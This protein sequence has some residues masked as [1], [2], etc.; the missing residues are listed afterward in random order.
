MDKVLRPECLDTDPNS[1][2]VAKEWLHWRRT[3][4]NFMAIL[5]HKDL[6]KLAVLSSFV[7]PKVSAAMHSSIIAT[8]QSSGSLSKS[9]VTINIGKL[10]VK[11]LFDSGSTESFIHPNLVRRSGLTV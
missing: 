6:D 9:T 5:P 1:G 4:E 11:A 7:S 10:Q 3:F 8:T 2:T